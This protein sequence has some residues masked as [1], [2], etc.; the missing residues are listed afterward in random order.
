MSNINYHPKKNLPL[1]SVIQS[2]IIRRFQN[3]GWLVVK[4]SLTNLSGLPDLM[5]LKDG[6]TKFIEVKRP[7]K[8]PRPLQ[9]YRHSQLRALGF[10]V[11]VLTE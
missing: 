2:R 1:E 8:K 11:E 9:E 10:E 6:I 5:A 3:E 4:L 7:D